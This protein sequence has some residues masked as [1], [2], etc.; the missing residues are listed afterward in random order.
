M[1]RV[2]DLFNRITLP[3]RTHCRGLFLIILMAPGLGADPQKKLLEV[4][5]YG[6]VF[7]FALR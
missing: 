7:L 4:S 5:N 1:N 3:S 2:C 6:L